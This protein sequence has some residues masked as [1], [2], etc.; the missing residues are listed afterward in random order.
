MSEQMTPEESFK[1]VDE[2]CNAMI[3]ALDSMHARI[4]R[5]EKWMLMKDKLK[6]Q[7]EK[8]KRNGSRAS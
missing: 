8:E 7:R 4:E 5:I 3:Q 1:K 6:L 2:L